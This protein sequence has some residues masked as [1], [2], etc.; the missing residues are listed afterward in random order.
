MFRKIPPVG[1]SEYFSL[2]FV[3]IVIL[4]VYSLWFR[5]VKVL[6]F[7]NQH[8]KKPHLEFDQFK[9][10]LLR[11]FCLFQNDFGTMLKNY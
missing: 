2:G 3:K 4:R 9:M 1:Y 11:F 5:I 10:I 6:F 8:R 7:F